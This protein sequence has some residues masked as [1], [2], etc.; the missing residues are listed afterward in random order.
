MAEGICTIIF[1]QKDGNP[2]ATAEILK[3]GKLNQ[4]YADERSGTPGGSLPNAEVK[5]AFNKWLELVPKSKFK[6]RRRKEKVAA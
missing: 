6:N 2:I 4:F 5:A 1:I 3:N